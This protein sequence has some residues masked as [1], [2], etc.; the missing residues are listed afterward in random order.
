[1]DSWVAMVQREVGERLA[2][3]PGGGEYGTPSVLAQLACEVRVLRA[4]P[5]TV[6]HPVPN[7]DSVLVALQR[8]SPTS[9]ATRARRAEPDAR[10]LRALVAGSFAHRRK[11]LAGSLALSGGAGGRSREQVRAALRELG[12][13]D[14]RAR[15]AAVARGLP[16]A[17]ERAVAVS[18]PGV[19]AAL[20]PA[21]VNLGL[22]LGRRRESD[23]RHELV[24]VM[25][26]ISLADEL[27]LQAAAPGAERDEVVCPGLD[28][29]PQ[30]NLAA[31]ALA[32]FREAT[33]W[34]A[35]AAAA[36]ASTSG[37]RWRR[38]SAAARPTLR[39]R[40]AW[41]AW[42]R[43]WATSGCCSSWRAELGAD[44]PAQIAPGRWL[45]TGAGEL[46][47]ALPDPLPALEL[48][49]LAS[50][51]QLSDG[52]RVRGGRRAGARAR[53]RRAAPARASRCARRWSWARRCRRRAS[54]CTTTCR[55][56]R[57]RCAPQIAQALAQLREAGADETLVSGSGPTVVGLFGHAN[58]AGRAQ[59]AWP[60]CA[61]GCRRR[62]PRNRSRRRS[63]GRA[64]CA[65]AARVGRLTAR[66]VTIAGQRTV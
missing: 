32:A 65:E 45:A 8:R 33:G 24:T 47:R 11:T 39:R 23:G 42:R 28:G 30:E 14:G 36:G 31:R 10:A 37:S 20:A 22:F 66:C 43:G 56:R 17:G 2:A 41:R 55:R 16:R 38:G 6:F 12:Q 27:R 57:V 61:S 64:G 34:A 49:V 40:C 9:P 15:R 4:I 3:S 48:L 52:G 50:P 58:P 59:R 35:G 19:Y 44:V 5:R 46:L 13:R 26:S 63:R 53:S 62:S 1:M 54:C 25:Q 7:V 21:K 18:E 60:D 51:A 29:A